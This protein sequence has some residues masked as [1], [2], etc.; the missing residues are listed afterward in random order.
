MQSAFELKNGIKMIVFTTTYKVCIKICN[1][2]WVPMYDHSYGYLLEDEE[3]YHKSLREMYADAYDLNPEHS[4]R[5]R[6]SAGC[7]FDEE[8]TINPD[9]IKDNRGAYIR[10]SIYQKVVEENKKLL[11]DIKILVGDYGP[12]KLALSD[13]WEKKFES[14]QKLNDTIWEILNLVKK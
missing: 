9:M 4:T 13:K 2:D 11:S 7:P 1:D 14:D 10:R 3:R 6:E 12:A 5:F 8:G